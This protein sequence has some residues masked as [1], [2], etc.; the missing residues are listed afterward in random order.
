VK[1]DTS[2]APEE[3]VE[4]DETPR[5]SSSKR[6]AVTFE[7][8]EASGHDDEDEAR[9][10]R[11]E[12]R[13]K[14]SRLDSQQGCDGP[15]E[16]P[17]PKARKAENTAKKREKDAEMAHKSHRRISK[18]YLAVEDLFVDL[19]LSKKER[20]RVLSLLLVDNGMIACTALPAQMASLAPKEKT[21]DQSSSS[22]GKTKA[23][24]GKKKGKQAAKPPTASPFTEAQRGAIAAL[25]AQVN[26]LVAQKD[27][28][29]N[30]AKIREL[31]GQIK[32]IKRPNST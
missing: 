20:K 15:A 21:A 25:K 30:L 32:E 7:D 10:R 11:R 22:K 9:I 16:T 8:N 2:S 4:E 26:E 18:A 29:D 5:K 1:D 14:R 17:A 6:K 13:E 24:K 31:R 19:E 28:A 12:R 23:K 3:D 27:S